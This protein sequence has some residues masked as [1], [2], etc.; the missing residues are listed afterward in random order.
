MGDHQSD[1]AA[2]LQAAVT[3]LTGMVSELQCEVQR[4]QAEQAETR[5]QA[6]AASVQPPA[7]TVVAGSKEP[8][9]KLP[10]PEKYDGSS[11][12]GA[13]ENFLFRCEQYFLRMDTPADKQV[14]FAAGLLIDGAA[15]WWRFS[16]MSHDSDSQASLYD[17]DEFRALLLTRFQ[18]VNSARHT[19]DQLANLVQS[20]SVRAYA[21]KMQELAM[22]IPDIKEGE[23]KDCFIRGLKRRTQEQVVMQDPDT[24]EKAV[25]LADRYDSLWGSANLFFNTR[26]TPSGTWATSATPPPTPNPFSSRGA[27]LGSSHPTPMEIDALQR[28]PTPLT[29]TERAHLIKIGGCFYCRQTGHMIGD[30]PNK[31]PGRPPMQ[32]KVANMERLRPLGRNPTSSTWLT[33]PGSRKTPCPSRRSRDVCWRRF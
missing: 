22:Q 15:S 4:L 12:P 7:P 24:F 23:L 13:A 20:G 1:A 27:N 17:W 10:I 32:R 29:Q 26:R 8:K 28:K 33:S 3:R 9:V 18:A 21:T 11:Q 6:A 2:M 25:K 5:E 16:C 14:L 19:R 30:C 31:P